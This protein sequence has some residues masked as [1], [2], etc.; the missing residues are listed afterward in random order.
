MKKRELRSREHDFGKGGI[1]ARTTMTLGISRRPVEG[2]SG[3][4]GIEDLNRSWGA[5]NWLIRDK[6]VRGWNLLVRRRKDEQKCT[7]KIE[8]E[9]CRILFKK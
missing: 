8:E 6:V 5:Y 1:L 3:E 9:S 2:I 4:L 7:R